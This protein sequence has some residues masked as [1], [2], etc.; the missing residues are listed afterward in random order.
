MNSEAY[1]CEV[2]SEIYR[3]EEELSVHM[4]EDHHAVYLP[5][6]DTDQEESPKLEEKEELM[7]EQEEEPDKSQ[8]GR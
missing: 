4:L 6:K 1:L 8:Y 7:K 5:I 3:H 2:C